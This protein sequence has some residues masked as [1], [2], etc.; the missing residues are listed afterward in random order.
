VQ[1]RLRFGDVQ[2]PKKQIVLFAELPRQIVVAVDDQ[3]LAVY[4][5]GRVG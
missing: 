3:G 2:P 4:L 5:Q 1:R